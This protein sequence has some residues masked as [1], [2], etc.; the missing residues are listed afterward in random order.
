MKQT[1]IE[2]LLATVYAVLRAEGADEAA[3]IVRG[4]PATA[5]LTGNDNWNGGTNYW[6]IRLTIPALEY[7]KL[8]LKRASLQEQITTALRMVTEH[9]Q[10]VAYSAL[11]IPAREFQADWRS[12]KSSNLPKSV[13]QNIADG[14]RLENVKWHGELNDVEFL[15]R[16]YELENLPSTD[17]RYK[18]A[19]G[20]IWQH[21]YNNDDW[22]D[23]WIFSDPRFNLFDGSAEAFLRFLCET[24]HPVVRPQREEAIKLVEHFNDQLHDAGWELYQEQQ[25]AGRP[26]FSYRLMSSD[27]AEANAGRS[28]MRAK[29]VVE[30]LSAGW[31]AKQ[32]ERMEYAV[33]SDPELAIGTA[34]ELIESCCKS[35]LTIREIPFTKADDLGNLTKKVTKALQLVPDGVSDAAKGAENIKN[36]LRNL[37]QLTSNLTQLRGLYGTGHGK[38]G[39]HRGLQPRHARLAIA[40]AVAFVDFV[41]ETHRYRE[42]TQLEVKR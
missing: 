38:D 39:Q 24:V 36:V 7:A 32:I 10:D 25:I 11:I 4:H 22:E 2:P 21:R 40:A 28:V 1:E 14:L 17:S 31:M 29:V 23:E 3:E 12:G 13:R 33:E 35:I 18:D 6:D 9:E 34:K 26:R 8:G 30:A 41:S 5:E 20:D 19:A 37:T 42:S 27:S 15:S 16:L